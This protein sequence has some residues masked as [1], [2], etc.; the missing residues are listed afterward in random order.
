MPESHREEDHYGSVGEEQARW[1][2]QALGREAGEDWFRIG[3]INHELE[4]LRDSATVR[5]LLG[6]HLDLVVPG[7]GAVS[8]H[9]GRLIT[10]VPG[11][12]VQC[13][14]L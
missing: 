3:L 2:A 5:S 12:E 10:L 4:E 9:L 7:R 14:D 8:N 11:A 13:R 6:P 1:F